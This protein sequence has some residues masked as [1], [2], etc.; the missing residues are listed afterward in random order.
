LGLASDVAGFPVLSLLF[1]VAPEEF[2]TEKI[3]EGIGKLL[4][5]PGRFLTV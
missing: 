3:P 1:I 5:S 4:V 2:F